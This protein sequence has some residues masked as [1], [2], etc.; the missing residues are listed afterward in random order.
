MLLHV[1]TIKHICISAVIANL[2]CVS[3]GVA[4][5]FF[6]YVLIDMFVFLQTDNSEKQ[7]N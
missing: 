5:V 6:I 3:R 2:F 7:Q 1:P 4:K